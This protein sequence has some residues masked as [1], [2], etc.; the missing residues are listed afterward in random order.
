MSRRL[1][2]DIPP[3]PP[4]SFTLPQ[5]PA[6]P[7]QPGAVTQTCRM[8]PF[9]SQAQCLALAGV[10]ACSCSASCFEHRG[11]GQ[12]WCKQGC[13]LVA[14]H[15]MPLWNLSQQKMLP[16]A[17]HGCWPSNTK[18]VSKGKNQADTA[19]GDLLAQ[20]G[21][22]K[23]RSAHGQVGSSMAPPQH[24]GG[25]EGNPM[26][27]CHGSASSAEAR[28]TDHK[29]VGRK[30]APDGR[31]PREGKAGALSMIYVQPST[32]QPS[33]CILLCCPCLRA[34]RPMGKALLVHCPVG[35]LEQE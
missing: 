12:A 8:W 23:Q 20:A 31:V 18:M 35:F 17:T 3:S 34:I 13:C 24:G 15:A 1:A 16:V 22:G 11:S 14:E 5:L 26:K 21:L 4:L 2:W 19:A 27:G 6:S 25:G 33:T 10:S 29:S 30:T 9:P 7:I 32:A 28:S